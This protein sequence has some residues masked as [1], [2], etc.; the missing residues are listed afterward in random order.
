MFMGCSNRHAEW[1][2][3]WDCMGRGLEQW[4]APVVWSFTSEQQQNPEKLVEYLEKIC[5][6]PDGPNEA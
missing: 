1:Q 3:V 5:C 2:G 4:A 6:H